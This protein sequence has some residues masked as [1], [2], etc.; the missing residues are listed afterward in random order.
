MFTAST[1]ASCSRCSSAC[2][3]VQTAA[4]EDHSARY[5]GSVAGRG[6]VVRPS[7]RLGVGRRRRLGGQRRRDVAGA[8]QA[9]WHQRRRNRVALLQRRRG[10]AAVT[11]EVAISHGAKLCTPS[12][13]ECVGEGVPCE[14]WHGRWQRQL[15]CAVRCTIPMVDCS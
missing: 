2:T 14:W 8:V 3:S 12:S 4:V 13:W 5:L 11:A 6:I 9:A 15:C 7:R 1:P 10:L